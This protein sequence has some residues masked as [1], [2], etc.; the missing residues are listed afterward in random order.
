[1]N[2]RSTWILL[3]I[4]LALGGYVYVSERRPTSVASS[5]VPWAAFDPA[6]IRSVELLRSNVV[7]RVERSTNGW[8]MTL[9]VRYVAQRSAVDS[10]LSGLAGLK[11][12]PVMAVEGSVQDLKGFGLDDAAI[13]VK[14]ESLSG[15]PTIYQ[16]GGAT[17]LGSQF[18]FRRVGADGV[19]S[20]EDTFLAL[21]PPKADY[22][23]DRSL[24]DLKGK[25]FDRVEVRG[26]TAFT[27]VRDSVS[28]RWRLVKPLP[29]RADSERIEAVIHALQQLPVAGFVSDSPLVDLAPLGLQ[30]PE[31]EL[32]LGRGSQD[33][34]HLQFG[35]A[36]TNAPDYVLVR[37]M[38]NTNLVLAPLQAGILLKLPLGNFRDRQLVPSLD[39]ATEVRFQ[40]GDTSVRVERN[41][42][43]WMVVEPTRFPADNGLINLFLHQ[44]GGLDIV[45]FPNDVPADLSKYGLD[46][47]RRRFAVLAGTNE[48]VRLEFGSNLGL[49]KVY[50]RRADEPSIYATRLAELLR[51]PETAGQIR[52]LRFDPTNVVEVSIE[53]KGRSRVLTRTAQGT[54]SVTRGAVGILIDE[55]VEET[56][57]RLGRVESARYVLPDP[58]QLE[59]LKF[60]EVAHTV[61]LKFRVGSGFNTLTFQFGGRN[62]ANNLMA[63]IR[64]DT[65]EPPILV[66]F[67]GA[68]YEDVFRDFSA[69]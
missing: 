33:L 11:P 67:P 5:G 57:Y 45:D 37:R 31:A 47:P 66:E 4:A 16:L 41:G 34:V 50:V 8:N 48:L 17:P 26:T 13:T 30:P 22:W 52:N 15:A 51:L 58:K 69:P 9:P 56:I 62:P 43:N 32:V 49:D 1:M 46:R 10:F 28:S 61:T 55:S 23:R 6:S 68:L 42:T 39:T 20:A 54:W 21:L 36:P 40:A 44:L 18:Y 27:A 38:A 64:F 19:F 3:L 63:L 24:F 29:A 12:R 7:I 25:E 35:R 59:L 53:Q 65:A 2:T 14:L 60:S